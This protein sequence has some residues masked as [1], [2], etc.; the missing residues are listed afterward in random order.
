M[1]FA[2]FACAA[3]TATLYTPLQSL[4]PSVPLPSIPLSLCFPPFN[5]SVPAQFLPLS[6]FL[7]RPLTLPLPLPRSLPLLPSLTFPFAHF[8]RPLS[9]T[10][11]KCLPPC[12]SPTLPLSLF[13]SCRRQHS[14]D[15]R[16]ATLRV[17]DFHL[18]DD[19]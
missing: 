2:A 16:C 4:S 6:P 9:A 18:V 12:R 17:L 13:S 19:E 1:G 15:S 8:S 14:Q 10:N 5:P 11:P 3:F 7:P